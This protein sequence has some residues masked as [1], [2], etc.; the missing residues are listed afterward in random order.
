V[1][2][3]QFVFMFGV[4]RARFEV[5]GS[6]LETSAVEQRSQNGESRPPEQERGTP[7]AEP[8]LEHELRSRNAEV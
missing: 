7:K 8:N 3:S 6:R 1:L 5:R 4:R 2:G